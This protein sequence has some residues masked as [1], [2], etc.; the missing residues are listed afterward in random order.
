MGW[1]SG[2]SLAA[3]VWQA[4]R[5]KIPAGEGR[6]I[7]A[8]KIIYEFEQCDCDTITEASDLC[9]DAGYL[10]DEEKDEHVYTSLPG[11]VRCNSLCE[12]GVPCSECPKAPQQFLY[13]TSAAALTVKPIPERERYLALARDALTPNTR[14]H[15]T[16]LADNAKTDPCRDCKFVSFCDVCAHNGAK[17]A[18]FAQ[19]PSPA[20]VNEAAVSR[21]LERERALDA[22]VERCGAC[23]QSDCRDCQDPGPAAP[24][25]IS[26][27]QWH[28][29]VDRAL[30]D[31]H[32]NDWKHPPR[33]VETP[34]WP[35][36]GGV[37]VRVAASGG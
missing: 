28:E 30:E 26:L 11:D 29:E 32:P 35:R 37:T 15:F 9:E 16:A 18:S 17:P 8:R 33:R 23:P 20:S 14:A 2:S 19:V 22:A 25:S 31:G 24:L 13:V 5:F 3:A 10:Y 27:D 4:I 1:S 6:M 12:I 7:A 36:R 21:E 34:A